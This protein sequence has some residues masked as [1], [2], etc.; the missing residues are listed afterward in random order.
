[1]RNLLKKCLCILLMLCGC[2]ACA[3]TSLKEVTSTNNQFRFSLPHGFTP[4]KSSVSEI[5]NFTKGRY[6]LTIGFHRK[7]IG[8]DFYRD[9]KHFQR[10]QFHREQLIFFSDIRR[11]KIN[12]VNVNGY[13]IAAVYGEGESPSMFGTM[14]RQGYAFALDTPGY[15]VHIRL[16][17]SA[18]SMNAMHRVKTEEMMR[19]LLESMTRIK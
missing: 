10:W 18:R 8:N 2:T 3:P 12:A 17:Y 6:D 15:Y 1:M 16:V 5:M 4:T 19:P 7:D 11:A 9:F 14:Y 13:P